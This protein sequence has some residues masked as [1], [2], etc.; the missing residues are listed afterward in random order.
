MKNKRNNRNVTTCFEALEGR[1]MFVAGALDLSFD[2]D[3]KVTIPFQADR[4]PKYHLVAS[5]VAVQ[6]DGKTLIGGTWRPVDVNGKGQWDFAVARLNF[7]GSLD[8]TFSN[9]GLAFVHVG[10]R[11]S[12]EEVN[13]IAVQTDGKILLAGYA[14]KDKLIFDD[15]EMAVARFL[16]NGQL[17]K[18]FAG[19]GT[20][21]ID[22]D[23]SGANDIALQRDGKIVVAGSSREGG[24]FRVGVARLH[25][26][27][28]ALDTSFDGDGQQTLDLGGQT[29]TANAI[30]LDNSG[31]SAT[32]PNFGKI[33]LVGNATFS[34][35]SQIAVARLNTNGSRDR[36]FSQDGSVVLS[37]YDSAVANDVLV[38][39]GGNIVVVGTADVDR[40]PN[41]SNANFSVV[42]FFA[43]GRV[44]TTFGGVKDGLIETG[45]GGTDVANGIARASDGGLLVSGTANGKYVLTKYS[46]DGCSTSSS[47][48]EAPPAQT[49]RSAL[50]KSR[51]PGRSA[52]GS[53]WPVARPAKPLVF[54]RKAQTSFPSRPSTRTRRKCRTKPRCSSRARIVFRSGLACSSQS[55]GARRRR[56]S[57]R[58]AAAITRS[59]ACPGR[60]A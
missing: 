56:A 58:S 4:F 38:Q 44:D 17:D 48:S 55:A 47:A 54:W 45:F 3:G 59:R 46:A 39:P 52:T 5:D 40:S 8:K 53:S 1:R 31:N 49:S 36:S 41:R 13:A 23:G 15:T 27:N 34:N 10:T 35:R 20:R 12:Q 30:A 6:S 50:A 42:R 28:G 43:N 7:D 25:M 51:S 32:D 18:S 57:S 16:P 9:D 26:S 2:K 60:M 14:K 22:F 37:R 11:N 24:K 21:F 19:G 29:S 33:V